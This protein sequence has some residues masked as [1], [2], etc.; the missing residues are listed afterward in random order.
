MVK[1]LII[2]EVHLLHGDRG[3]V[4]EALV[5][6]TLRQVESSQVMIRIVGLSATLPNYIDV[7]H[8][9]RVNPYK[10]LFY[11]D[12]RFRPV[13]L[14]QTF[15]GVK[16]VNSM[17]QMQEMDVVCY[18]KVVQMVQK[19]HQVMVFVHARNATLKTA[20]TLREMAQNRSQ[21]H[22]FQPEDNA[23]L[24]LATKNVNKSRNKHLVD[25]FKDGFAIH[26]AGMLRTDRNLVEKMFADGM[27]RVLVCTAT[28]AWGVN[29][30]AHAVV[31]KGRQ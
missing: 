19:G 9:L 24:G 10:G 29:L 5:A 25:L 27:A 21:L 31:I 16:E 26:H 28:L 13:P 2:D 11:F 20:Q 30:P 14:S 3:P 17:R 18:E 22:L 15:I 1:L 12:S 7:A 23:A 6:R 4:V 8:F